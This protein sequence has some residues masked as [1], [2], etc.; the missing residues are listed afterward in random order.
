MKKAAQRGKKSTPP[1]ALA[2]RR[3]RCH[4]K[5]REGK[6][7]PASP[8][9]GKQF[10]YWHIPGNA[11]EQ[12]TIG[13]RRRAIYD[14][15]KLAKIELPE[16]AADMRRLLAVGLLELWAGNLD[17]KVANTV[18]FLANSFC[19]ALE[20]ERND[21]LL[22]GLVEKVAKLEEEAERARRSR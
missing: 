13:G 18:G 21:T 12:G 11:S 2:P 8:V 6:P 3:P 17:P 15:E 19:N 20:S 1:L 22:A 9:H 16:K 4:A 5:T 10:C 7:C 14:P